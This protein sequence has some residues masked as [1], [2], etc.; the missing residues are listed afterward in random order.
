MFLDWA[1]LVVIGFGCE[2]VLLNFGF[3]DVFRY[4]FF[5]LGIVLCKSGVDI[6]ILI[7]FILVIQIVKFLT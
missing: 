4:F 7:Q 6:L 5:A 2:G 3:F 1:W